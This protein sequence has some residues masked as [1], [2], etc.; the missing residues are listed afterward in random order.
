[1]GLLGCSPTD[2]SVAITLDCLELYHQLRRRQSSFSIQAMCKVL[3]ALHNVCVLVDYSTRLLTFI[4]QVT[5]SP[6]FRNQLSIAFDIYLDIL[7]R[8]GQIINQKLGRDTPDWR[9][10]NACPPCGYKVHCMNFRHLN[11]T[12]IQSSSKVHRPLFQ[13]G[14]RLW[15]GICP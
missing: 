13:P 3:C 2:P 11:H 6:S 8:V 7:R 14:F 10:L 12:D 1:M 5:Y 4:Y 15:M 9:L